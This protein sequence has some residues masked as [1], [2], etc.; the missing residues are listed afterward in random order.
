MLVDCVATTRAANF[1]TTLFFSSSRVTDNKK[2]ESRISVF[3]Y[4]S[5]DGLDDV[6]QL[7]GE[8]EPGSSQLLVLKIPA[9]SIMHDDIITFKK[10]EE[11]ITDLTTKSHLVMNACTFMTT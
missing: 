11:V 5:K 3:G 8:F 1:Y 2:F 9:F 7:Q 10:Y 4:R 6:N